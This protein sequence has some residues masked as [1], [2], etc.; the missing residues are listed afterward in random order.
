[1]GGNENAEACIFV[2]AALDEKAQLH[3]YGS[4]ERKQAS[5]EFRQCSGSVNHHLS[6]DCGNAEKRMA[7][8]HK[9]LHQPAF[10]NVK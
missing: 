7:C 1:M 8:M 6:I 4:G 3:T 9:G 5:L 10:Y 2:T